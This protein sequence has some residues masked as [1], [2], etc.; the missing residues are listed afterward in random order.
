MN[1]PVIT[2]ILGTAALGLLKSSGS[3]N[4]EVTIYSIDKLI[5]YAN[6]PK[7]APLVIEI[8]LSYPSSDERIT[9]IPSEIGNLRNL[10]KIDL[11]DNDLTTLPP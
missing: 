11:Q 10:L 9:S 8:D 3:K 7:K 4:N 1:K 2:T 6:D 5:E